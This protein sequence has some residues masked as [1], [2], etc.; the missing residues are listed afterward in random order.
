MNIPLIS[1][2]TRKVSFDYGVML[3][4]DGHSLRGLF[5]IDDKGIIR[6]ISMNDP[7]V[8]RNIDEVLRLVSA[9]QYT[10]K[11]GSVCPANWKPGQN[12]INVN[13]KLE[14]FSKVKE[15]P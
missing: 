1:D 4:K 3:I 13:N 8:G 11:H 6:H 7:P 10:D 5:I 12:T 14:Y 2:L 15:Q 9:Y